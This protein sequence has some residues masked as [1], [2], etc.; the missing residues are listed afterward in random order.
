VEFFATAAK[1]TEPA[2][3]DE[4]RELR[5]PGV[6]CDRGGVHFDAEWQDAWRVCLGSRI[7][8]RVYRPLSTFEA[9]S[10]QA[11]YDGVRAID[12]SPYL[13]P[14]HTLAVTAFCKSSALT[15]TNFTAQ[16]VKDA[17]VDQ[18]RDRH[19]LR[20][21]VDRDDPDVALF[22][23]LAKDRATVYLDLAGE[24]LHRRGYRRQ[25]R[26][27]P[28]KESL[29]AALVRLSGWDRQRPFCDPMC[30]S[31]TIAIEAALWAQ[32]IAPG[33]LRKRFGFERWP[34]FDEGARRRL[35]ALRAEA[36][37]GV[38]SERIPIF[39]S[40]LDPKAVEI[41]LANARAAG[42]QLVISRR[43][44]LDLKPL[45]PPGVI[46]TN[47]PYG[48]RLQAEQGLYRKMGQVFR[49]LPGH[50]VAVLTGHRGIQRAIPMKPVRFQI[51]Y[52][53][54]I[55]CRLVVYQVHG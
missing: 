40:D 7:A 52:N 13:T 50:T 25:A 42:V 54:D 22:L 21:D 1:G 6:R 47:P 55:E 45:D 27:A 11:L 18:L 51:V 15:H 37:A 17:I 43:S 34:G 41:A 14:R 2:L 30:G 3:R 23:H 35:Q 4:L 12:W 8:L 31:G 39:A 49:K 33:M 32:N 20:P 28:L 36:R 46:L 9:P 44:V 38:R 29:A 26:E 53:G 16:K 5:I 19:G 48:E 24:S 10:K